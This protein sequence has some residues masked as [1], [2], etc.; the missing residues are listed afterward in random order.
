MSEPISPPPATVPVTTSVEANGSGRVC[1]QCG[2]GDE[3]LDCHRDGDRLV[4][5]HKECVRFWERGKRRPALGPLGD[6]LD[7]LR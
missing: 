5:L 4:W 2:A 6:S 1:A 3:P 7:D